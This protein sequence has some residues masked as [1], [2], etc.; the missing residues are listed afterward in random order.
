MPLDSTLRNI[1]YVLTIIAIALLTVSCTS[2]EA[3]DQKGI[4]RYYKL[5]C[6][7]EETG[8]L[9][10]FYD[11]KNNVVFKEEYAVEP[12]IN[13]IANTIIEV[14]INLGSLNVY[15]YFYDTATQQRSEVF[16]N[17]SYIEERTIAYREGDE[18]IITDIFDKT[19]LYKSIV[20]GFSPTAVP[21]H[22][23]LEIISLEGGRLQIEYL[24]GDKLEITTE[25]INLH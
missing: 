17:P 15:V 18:L 7:E 8:Y 3:M 19:L 13:V 1:G 20:R 4:D 16:Y 5:D 10:T 21:A 2:K 22:S 6:E 24:R 25:V 12:S 11:A 23:I 9:L 14:R